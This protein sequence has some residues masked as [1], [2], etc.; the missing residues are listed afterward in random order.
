MRMMRFLAL[1][2]ASGC[3]G[4]SPPSSNACTGKVYDP[5]IEE[6]DCN[7][8]L[9]QNYAADGFQVCSQACDDAT[10]CPGDGTCVDAVCK[11]AAPNDCEL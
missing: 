9:C 3:A 11:P 7:A 10:P 1:I 2:V 5:C 4:D 6:H 8:G